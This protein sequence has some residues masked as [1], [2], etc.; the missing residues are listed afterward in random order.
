MSND[1]HDVVKVA[2][3][4]MVEM[5][6]F[7]QALGDAGIEARAVGESLDA[8][9]GTALINS[10]E[11]WVQQCDA[12]RARKIIDEMEADRA[13]RAGEEEEA[14]GENGAGA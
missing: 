14:N 8:S 13:R 11:L 4:E 2:V 5:E 10:V 6:L 9:L 12:E 1:P 3:G 7:K